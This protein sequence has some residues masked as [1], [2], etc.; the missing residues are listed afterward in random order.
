MKGWEPAPE[1]SAYLCGNSSVTLLNRA[2]THRGDTSCV[3]CHPPQLQTEGRYTA[4]DLLCLTAQGRL[5]KRHFPPQ[6]E[7]GTKSR[8]AR[9]SIWSIASPWD[10]NE[11]VNTQ[12]AQVLREESFLS[13]S[14]QGRRKGSIVLVSLCH[15]TRVTQCQKQTSLAEM[16]LEAMAPCSIA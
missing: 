6:M 7:V 4:A 1:C 2:L 12:Y 3:L 10:T 9:C 13:V 5:S 15:N 8:L 14:F 11:F 16:G